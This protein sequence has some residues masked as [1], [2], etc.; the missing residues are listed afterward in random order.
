MHADHEVAPSN[1]SVSRPVNLGVRLS[2][3]QHADTLIE[4][5]LKA[6]SFVPVQTINLVSSLGISAVCISLCCNWTIGLGA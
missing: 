3:Q 4:L 1:S 5:V 6:L 2:L